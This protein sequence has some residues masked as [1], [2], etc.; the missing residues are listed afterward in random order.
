M[1]STFDNSY[2][3]IVKI[4]RSEGLIKNPVET[5]ISTIKADVQPYNGGLAQKEY[6]LTEECQKRMY[7]K[8]NP[9]V[10]EGNSCYVDDVLYDIIYVEEWETGTV[11][12]LKRV[13]P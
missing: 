11:A 5:E 6:G 3:R 7:Y 4:T 10:T 1:W 13:T 2:V 12:V 8:N 9:A